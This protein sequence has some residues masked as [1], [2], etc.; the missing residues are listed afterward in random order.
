MQ[1]RGRDRAV[2]LAALNRKLSHERRLPASR[3][4]SPP[5][6]ASLSPRDRS[7]TPPRTL[8]DQVH[9]AYADD[10][11]HL[12]KVLLLRLQ[13]IEVTSDSDPRIAAVRDEDFDA[14]FIPFGRLDD[15]RGE[16]PVPKEC[17][18]SPPNVRRAD[19]LRAKERL[20]E[21]EARRFTEERCR[22]AALKRRQSDH[23]RAVSMEQDR[24]RL[25]KQK[26]AAAAAVDLRRRRVSHTHSLQLSILSYCR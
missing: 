21:T 6:S 26:E 18:T 15:G 5:S 14:C 25:I 23:Q 24:L 3:S 9:I 8:S 7:P 1:R 16:Q 4:P 11:I 13:G 22:Q 10:D 2:S 20:W 17:R 19:A 12:A